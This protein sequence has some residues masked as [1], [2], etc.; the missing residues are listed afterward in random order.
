M[1][2]VFKKL[3]YYSE[4]NGKLESVSRKRLR[5]VCIGAT[6][7]LLVLVI[8]LTAGYIISNSLPAHSTTG[9]ST[10]VLL[11]FSSTFLVAS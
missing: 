7:G 2:Q 8:G 3:L 5:V 11:H 6:M 9:E 1:D 10:L 4:G